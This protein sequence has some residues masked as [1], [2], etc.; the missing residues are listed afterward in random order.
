MIFVGDMSGDSGTY[1]V[2]DVFDQFA[3]AN[4]LTAFTTYSGRNVETE[5]ELTLSYFVP[6]QEGWSNGKRQV[7]CY[8]IRVDGQ[9]MTQSV[10]A[11]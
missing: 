9:P 8:A 11:H 5:Q 2:S 7:I 10:K 3:A 4:C 6:N 1:P